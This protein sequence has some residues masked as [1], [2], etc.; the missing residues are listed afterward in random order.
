MKPRLVG[1]LCLFWLGVIV[2]AGADGRRVW[3]AQ[4]PNSGVMK[5]KYEEPKS[6]SGAIYS[7]ASDDRKLLFNFKRV[8]HRTG[9][10]LTVQRD[11]TY[12]D[13]KP[14]VRER[15]VYEGDALVSYEL[16]ELQTGAAGGAK[17]RRAPENQAK[18]TIQFEYRKQAGDRLKA[19]TEALRENTLINDM[20]G[21]FLASHWDAL[22]R[23][24]A[25]DCRM[26]VLPRRETVGFTFVK[27]PEPAGQGGGAICLRMEAISPFVAVLV[28]PLVFQIEKAPP[29]RVLQYFGRTTPKIQAGSKWKDLD[30]LTVFNW[31]SA[32]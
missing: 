8:A 13:G 10:T 19:G 21:P 29:H 26:I 28:D 16:E 24:E 4:A 2:L 20:V 17:I 15:V 23:G 6:L 32:R 12:P 3:G 22:L 5:L 14:A 25:V 27:S 11:Y 1:S 7:P 31:G 30:A 18:G 9:S